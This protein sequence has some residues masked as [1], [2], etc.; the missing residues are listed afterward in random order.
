MDI[1]RLK[2]TIAM[3]LPI[4]QLAIGLTAAVDL[5]LAGFTNPFS[6]HRT[7]LRWR[8]GSSLLFFSIFVSIGG[9]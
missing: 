8:N 5:T 7:G 9:G 4:V 3:D 2:V 1:R 6:N